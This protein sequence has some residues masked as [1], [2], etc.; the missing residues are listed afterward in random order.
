MSRYTVKKCI[1]HSRTFEEI[2]LYAETN[3]IDDVDEL[4]ADGY[5]STICG[6]CIPYVSKML[7]SGQTEFDPGTYQPQ[8]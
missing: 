5:C 1:C 8:D 3:N 7:E 4:V 2:K 6:L